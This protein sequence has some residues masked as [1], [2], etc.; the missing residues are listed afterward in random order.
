MTFQEADAIVLATAACLHDKHGDVNLAYYQRLA[1]NMLISEAEIPENPHDA[2]IEAYSIVKA[3]GMRRITFALGRI[4]HG[5]FRR[6]YPRKTIE[7]ALRMA[8]KYP[9]LPD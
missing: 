5:Q 7:R 3:K 8:M 2:S 4:T 6:K 9:F 1:L